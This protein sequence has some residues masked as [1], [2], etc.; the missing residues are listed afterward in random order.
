MVKEQARQ[1]VK[2]VATPKMTANERLEDK[3]STLLARLIPSEGRCLT[4][5]ERELWENEL[6]AFLAKIIAKSGLVFTANYEYDPGNLVCTIDKSWTFRGVEVGE[7]TCSFMVSNGNEAITRYTVNGEYKKAFFRWLE[8]LLKNL[9][10]VIRGVRTVIT[11]SIVFIAGTIDPSQCKCG[12]RI[13][14]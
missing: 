1:H 2:R 9:V 12:G 10:V 6:G 7:N 8:N 3:L 4:N 5:I 14:V 13:M 11:S